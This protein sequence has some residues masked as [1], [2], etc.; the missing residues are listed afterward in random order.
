VFLTVRRLLV[1]GC[2]CFLRKCPHKIVCVLR[3]H[4]VY[5]DFEGLANVLDDRMDFQSSF[6][7]GLGLIGQNVVGININ[8]LKETK[9]ELHR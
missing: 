1:L 9:N 6:H 4:G 2:R 5:M 7:K 3:K 8:C